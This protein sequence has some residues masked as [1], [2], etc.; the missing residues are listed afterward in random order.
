MLDR[1]LGEHMGH[2]QQLPPA[3]FGHHLEKLVIVRQMER[4]V[5][6]DIPDLEY[7]AR[8]ATPRQLTLTAHPGHPR[9]HALQVRHSRRRGKM[10]TL[11]RWLQDHAVVDQEQVQA[12][13][14]QQ[15][16]Q[17][18]P[19]PSAPLRQ[20]RG[21]VPRQDTEGKAHHK[22]RP[23]LVAKGSK[24]GQPA[25]GQ[26]IEEPILPQGQEQPYHC[27]AGPEP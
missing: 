16:G 2:V 7:D 17:G 18:Q 9:V 11:R 25:I 23:L 26:R 27:H 21:S 1:A 14:A 10:A 24:S 13:Q 19:G 6:G 5:S 8:V 22:G 4:A 3:Q 20:G 15:H 12:C